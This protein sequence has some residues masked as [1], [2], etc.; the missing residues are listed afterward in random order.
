MVRAAPRYGSSTD[1]LSFEPGSGGAGGGT[2]G[3][4]SNGAGGDGGI[5]GGAV[6]IAGEIVTVNGAVRTNGGAGGNHTPFYGTGG[7][8][9]SGGTLIVE[10]CLLYGTGELESTG[11]NGGNAS[12]GY[13]YLGGGGGGGGGRVAL[14]NFGDFSE[15]LVDVAG[16]S[17]GTNGSFASIAAESGGV[18]EFARLDYANPDGDDDGFDCVAD[19]CPLINN[20]LQEGCR[21]GQ[22]WRHL[23]PLPRSLRSKRQ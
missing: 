5:G 11:G 7:G 16:G 13:V 22:H 19:N 1:P 21:R 23:R 12:S 15:L 6:L 18:G 10:A 14:V 20:P 4:G 17:G 8:G 3:P 9:G 2:Y